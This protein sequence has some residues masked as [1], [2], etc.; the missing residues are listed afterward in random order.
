MPLDWPWEG[1]TSGSPH[2][3]VAP[4]RLSRLRTVP[5]F[6]LVLDN[7]KGIS[8]ATLFSEVF[9]TFEIGPER[10]IEAVITSSEGVETLVET[11]R[12]VLYG[13][14]EKAERRTVTCLELRLTPG[15]PISFPGEAASSVSSRFE[16]EIL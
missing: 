15:V 5:G 4:S 7:E 9:E 3:V 8:F 16:R 14:Y 11:W 12:L 6:G 2:V 1:I 13:C 10:I